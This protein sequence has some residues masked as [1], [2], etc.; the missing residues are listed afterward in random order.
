MCF[1]LSVKILFKLMR[2]L[3]RTS[4]IIFDSVGWAMHSLV[5]RW[6]YINYDVIFSIFL[7][8]ISPINNLMTLVY[9]IG[10]VS[11]T[12]RLWHVNCGAPIL[13]DCIHVVLSSLFITKAH[14][15]T[16]YDTT[17]AVL[18]VPGPTLPHAQLDCITYY[19]FVLKTSW[20]VTW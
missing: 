1:L 5:T 17:L 7:S 18:C 13:F 11:L 20:Y 14:A 19:S 12:P 15:E 9:K 10:T 6:C 3:T 2:G 8:V 16:A 4:A